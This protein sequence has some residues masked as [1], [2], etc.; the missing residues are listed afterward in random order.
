M[1]MFFVSSGLVFK[2]LNGYIMTKGNKNVRQNCIIS[3]RKTLLTGAQSL[4][5]VCYL[6][7]LITFH[8]ESQFLDAL[9]RLSQLPSLACAPLLLFVQ[10]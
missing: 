10:F 6:P 8:A 5:L 4:K 3:R 1:V 7:L 2:D 9:S